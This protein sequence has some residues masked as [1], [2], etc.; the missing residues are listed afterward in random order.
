MYTMGTV[1]GTEQGAEAAL[2]PKIAS[3]EMRC[4]PSASRASSGTDTL[5]L[6]TTA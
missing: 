1:S 6:R 5:S 3:G 4:R 2:L